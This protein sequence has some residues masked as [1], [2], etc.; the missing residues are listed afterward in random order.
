MLMGTP[1]YMSPEQCRG[2]KQ[3]DHRS[4]I[5]SLGLMIY[6][7]LAGEP[8]FMSEGMGE[9]FHLHM[10]VTA[11]PLRERLP[12]IPAGLSD[13]VDKAL[14]KDP[15]ARFANMGELHAALLAALKTAPIAPRTDVSV[16]QTGR[17]PPGGTRLTS[18]GKTT[19]SAAAGQA[20]GEETLDELWPERRRS[21]VPMAV[22]AVIVLGAGAALGVRAMRP[23][24]AAPVAAAPV[25]A[26]VKPVEPPRP[27]EVPVAPK[28]APAEPAPPAEP[29]RISVDIATT[30]SRV[31][32]I[33][34]ADGHLIGISPF[35][36]LLP[37]GE[38]TLQVRL[39]K[40]GY[41]PRTVSI[42]RNQKFSGTFELKRVPGGDEAAGERIIKL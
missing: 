7:M 38:G 11:T 25:P 1:L 22:A 28:P 5:Y 32:L 17:L 13:V 42:P 27:P 15:A 21:R 39:E 36:D 29:A 14:A 4:D 23:G 16:E 20:A 41:E 30:P 31:R 33:D 10:N 12:S 34:T 18:A 26:P 3:V 2:T 6:Q 19:L 40:K 24:P 35:H 37:S 8:P 9:L